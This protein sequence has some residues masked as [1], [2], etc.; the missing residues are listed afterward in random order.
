[1]HNANA[2]W[3]K[4]RRHI[5]DQLMATRFD[6]RWW[7]D[8]KRQEEKQDQHTDDAPGSVTGSNAESPMPRYKQA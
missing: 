6:P 8:L 2:Y 3:H 4:Q 5:T 1:M 7:D